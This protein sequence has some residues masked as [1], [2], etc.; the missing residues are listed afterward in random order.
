MLFF[1]SSFK[2]QEIV[3]V[4]F[5]LQIITASQIKRMSQGEVRGR[6]GCVGV[7]RSERR[8]DALGL[9]L[10]LPKGAA[11]LLRWLG[12]VWGQTKCANFFVKTYCLWH[13]QLENE[14]ILGVTVLHFLE[15]G[16]L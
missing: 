2:L 16:S 1:F 10:A 3:L 7:K 15:D 13:K 12:T 8:S 9:A 6:R 14:I 11:D 4:I 5:F